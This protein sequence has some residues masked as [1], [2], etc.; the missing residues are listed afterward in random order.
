MEEQVELNQ[1]I[2]DSINAA[3][4]EYNNGHVRQQKEEQGRSM[5]ANAKE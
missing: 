1:E 2:V 4:Y 5:G 3:S